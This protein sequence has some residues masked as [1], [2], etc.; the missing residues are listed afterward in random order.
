MSDDA[1]PAEALYDATMAEMT[2]RLRAH[3]L[4][5]RCSEHPDATHELICAT[6]SLV[7]TSDERAGMASDCPDGEQHILRC[8]RCEL[9]ATGYESAVLPRAPE[10]DLL[11]IWEEEL[12]I[13]D[14]RFGPHGSHSYNKGASDYL[15]KCIKEVRAARAG[16][17]APRS[18]E[19]KNDDAV[20]RRAPSDG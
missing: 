15:S 13:L 1:N 18:S 17:E 12:A 8:I 4:I 9:P 16:A 7:L 11:K 3:D 14:E 2:E 20:S 10:P 5:E 19:T 6:C